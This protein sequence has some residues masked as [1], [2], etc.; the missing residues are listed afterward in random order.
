MSCASRLIAAA[1][2]DEEDEVLIDASMMTLC[3]FLPD[4]AATR[5]WGGL[6]ARSLQPGLQIQLHGTLGAGKTTW[7]RALLRQLGHTGTVKSPTYGLVEHYLLELNTHSRINL[8]H[9]DFYRFNRNEEW[10]E[11]GCRDYF[12]SDSICLVEWPEQAGDL[13]PAPDL[14]VSLDYLNQDSESGRLLEI[15]AMTDA[16]KTCLKRLFHQMSLSMPA[17]A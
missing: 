11:A 14:S 13:L 7:V 17:D 3:N 16:G 8:Y 4:E 10:S 2:N 12:R 6:M 9:F 1:D 15:V 5:H